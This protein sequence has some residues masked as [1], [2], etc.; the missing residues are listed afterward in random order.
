M[1][2]RDDMKLPPGRSCADCTNY[3]RCLAF[4]GP[5]YINENATRCD[6]A[7]SRFRLADANTPQEPG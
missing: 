1:T 3:H 7:P 4:I 5:A 2:E 6:W